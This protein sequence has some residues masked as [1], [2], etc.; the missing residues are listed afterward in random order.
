MKPKL[1]DIKDMPDFNPLVKNGLTSV[2]E[3]KIFWTDNNKVTCKEHGACLC[4]NSDRSIW[5]CQTCN[6]GAYVIWELTL[7]EVYNKL[8][9][10]QIIELMTE[11]FGEK[12]RKYHTLDEIPLYKLIN[13]VSTNKNDSTNP[14]SLGFSSNNIKVVSKGGE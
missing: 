14:N 13:K 12:N 11:S 9:H 1:I 7:L 6:E 10:Q 4:L 2:S 8:T 3:G 5:R